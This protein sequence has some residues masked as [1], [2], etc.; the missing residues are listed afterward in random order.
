[1]SKFASPSGDGNKT[2]NVKSD[3]PAQNCFIYA[4]ICNSLNLILSADRLPNDRRRKAQQ[5]AKKA[6]GSRGAR[7]RY[8]R[9]RDGFLCPVVMGSGGRIAA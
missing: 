7:S 5:K 2:A 9:F 4:A 8:R 1:M 3:G 6:F